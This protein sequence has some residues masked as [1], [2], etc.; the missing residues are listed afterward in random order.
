MPREVAQQFRAALDNIAGSGLA[1]ATT[2]PEPKEGGG[3]GDAA[4]PEQ[5]QAG[6]PPQ[7]SARK[8]L[9]A[10]TPSETVAPDRPPAGRNDVLKDLDD[11]DV[12]DPRIETERAFAAQQRRERAAMQ[13]VGAARDAGRGEGDRAGD[14]T[15]PLGNGG[16]A[17]TTELTPG[18]ELLLPDQAANDGRRIRLEL[19]PEA[20]LSGVAPPPAGTSGDWIRGQEQVIDRPELSAEDRKV[21]GRYFMRSAE[22]RGP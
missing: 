4:A 9:G 2:P 14:G 22:G 10:R 16:L 8:A 3:A 12:V 15:R 19:P 7:P 18:G 13:S 1:D 20:A 17:A 21:V 5:N 11:Y 6:R